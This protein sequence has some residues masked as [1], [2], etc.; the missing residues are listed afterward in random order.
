MPPK[1]TGETGPSV[2]VRAKDQGKAA[3]KAAQHMTASAP[4]PRAT[5]STTTAQSSVVVPTATKEA[6]T[7]GAKVVTKDL[8]TTFVQAQDHRLAQNLAIREEFL[9]KRL[10]M[11]CPRCW[12]A[13]TLTLNGTAGKERKRTMVRCN[14]C[15]TKI[16][17]DKL[18]KYCA[19]FETSEAT[20]EDSD[21]EDEE[22]DE[23]AEDAAEGEAEAVAP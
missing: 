15:L 4:K 5:R 14:K 3:M 2:K 20:Y 23:E 22:K 21:E 18:K 7:K 13:G 8:P 10:I 12:L 9:S 17:G 6:H 16:S 1:P 19:R 11:Y